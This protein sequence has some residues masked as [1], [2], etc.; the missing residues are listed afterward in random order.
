MFISKLHLSRRTF[1]RGALGTAISLP[2]LDAM[3]PALTAQSKTAAKGK[4]RF[5]AVYVPNGVL[6]D[7]WHPTDVGR[8]FQFSPVMKP[9]EP[10]REQ[11][12]TVSG[13]V[14]SGTPGRISVQ[15]RLAE[16]AGSDRQRRRAH[17]V[18][19]VARPV[20][21][22]AYWPGHTLALARSRDRGHGL[23][24]RRATDLPACAQ[25]ARMEDRHAAA[26]GRD[27]PAD[28]L[29]TDVRRDRYDGAAAGPPALPAERADSVAADGCLLTQKQLG[30]GD[31]R[32]L[33]DYLENVRE[34]ERRI[35]Q[36]MKRSEQSVEAPAAPTGVPES[37]DEHMTITYDLMHLAFQGDITRVSTFLTGVEASNRGYGIIGIPESHHVCS[38]HGNDPVQM[39]KYTT[40]VSWQTLQFAKFVK[41]LQDTPD[42]DGSL[43]DHSLLY[44]GG[45]MSNG[46]Q[47]DRN[48][49]PA[50][51]VGGANGRMKGNNHVAANR[52]PAVNLLLNIAEMADVRVE[53]IGSS[54]GR[55]DLSA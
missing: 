6:P 42:G 23:A 43:L 17:P 8:D 47:H 48:T 21:R 38:H 31:Q 10:F 3:V 24:A 7:R 11:L 4:F 51:L 52:A 50:V 41:K 46:N 20:H 34:V 5:G 13:L 45:G 33:N 18:R 28:D 29:R 26:A 37:F 12:I 32:I 16:R 35:Q 25:R 27:Q 44:F 39:D 1:L 2:L 22:R 54:T 15:L 14:A 40:I 53:K 9:L 36:I 49:P 30:P 19:E 55:L